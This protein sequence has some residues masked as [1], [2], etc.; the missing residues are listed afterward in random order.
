MLSR[1][2]GITKVVTEHTFEIGERK[3]RMFGHPGFEWTRDS[4][5]GTSEFSSRK[6]D[7]I[8]SYVRK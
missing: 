6:S 5:C 7:T 1:A 3:K 8:F 2:R 4:I